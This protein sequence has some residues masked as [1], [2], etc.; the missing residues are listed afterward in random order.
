MPLNIKDPDTHTLAKRL[1]GLTGESL[2]KAVKLAIQERLARVE[3]AQAY[4]PACRRTGPHCPALR[5]FAAPQPA[6]R[7]TDHR[8]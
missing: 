1:A 7:R 4:H 3:K 8:L 2:T 6:E 5:R